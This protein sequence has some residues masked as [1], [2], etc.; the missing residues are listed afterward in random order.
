MSPLPGLAGTPDLSGSYQVSGPR[1]CG[2]VTN[3]SKVGPGGYVSHYTGVATFTPPASGAQGRLVLEP[4]GGRL[5]TATHHIGA[6]TLSFA[7]EAKIGGTANPY[8]L[9]FTMTDSSGSEALTGRIVFGGV[10]AGIADRAV[11]LLGARD[12]KPDSCA[13]QLLLTR[14]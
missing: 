12:A 10:R 1:I 9:G 6:A 2:V 3:G 5:I 14:D 4:I 13:S 11:L 7:V 8:T